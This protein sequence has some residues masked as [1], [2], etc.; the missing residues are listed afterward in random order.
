MELLQANHSAGA[1]STFCVY[2]TYST[3]FGRG[4]SIVKPVT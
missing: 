4:T 1:K 3:D 2:C